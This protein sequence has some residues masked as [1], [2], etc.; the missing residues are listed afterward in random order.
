VRWEWGDDTLLRDLKTLRPDWFDFESKAGQRRPYLFRLTGLAVAR[1]RTDLPLSELGRE[2]PTSAPPPHELRKL[3]PQKPP[4]VELREAVESDNQSGE[5]PPQE[6]PHDSASSPLN[7]Y[8]YEGS[9]VEAS[10]EEKL[11]H[12]VGKTTAEPVSDEQEGEQGLLDDLQALVDAGV[13]EWI[14][15]DTEGKR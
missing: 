11:D 13:G 6:P 10:S 9:E 8:L 2:T 15:D 12:A 1:N 14:E 4:H 5:Q 7:S 3:A